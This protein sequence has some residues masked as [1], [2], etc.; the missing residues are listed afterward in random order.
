M[1]FT[2]TNDSIVVVDDV[3]GAL[4]TVRSDASNFNNL[5]QALE[6]GDFE[7]AKKHLSPST[8]LEA[9]VKGFFKVDGQM[10]IYRNERV[11]ENLVARMKEMA[12]KGE[13]PEPLM[14]FW[15]KL[16]K[17]PSM[18]SVS[19]LFEFLNHEGIPILP[20]G[21][22]LAYKGVKSNY[23]DAHSGKV[24]NTPGRINEMPRNKISDDPKEA[25]HYGFHVGAL[26]YAR[27]FSQ[28]VIVCEVD[29]TDVVCIPYDY[30]HQKMRVCK[31]KVVGNHNGELLPSTS[32]ELEGTAEA[33]VVTGT[34]EEMVTVDTDDTRDPNETNVGNTLQNKESAEKSITLSNWEKEII[35]SGQFIMAIK[36]L[37]A[38]TGLG[39]QEAKNLADVYRKEFFKKQQELPL[40]PQKEL[41]NPRPNDKKVV[42]KVPAQWKKMH[43]MKLND[44]MK[45]TI[46]DLRIYASKVLFLVGASKIPGGKLALCSQIMKVRRN[47]K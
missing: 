2:R 1:K 44:L 27:S 47:F 31:Y 4:T 38:R 5:A 46:E 9:W 8:S 32:Y 23:T 39:L 28:I 18:R 12:F 34:K 45:Q 29:P 24:D 25:C 20:N 42:L 6:K 21:N 13:S 33:Q 19:Q 15:E 11:P 16:Q 10:V 40:K 30:N 26:D 3:T 14:R 43:A 22:F 17:N 35:R 41:K 7:E 36:E 37:R